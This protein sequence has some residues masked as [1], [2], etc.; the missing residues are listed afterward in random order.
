LL[1]ELAKAVDTEQ[2]EEANRLSATTA[3]LIDTINAITHALYS[4]EGSE[5]QSKPSSFLPFPART[6]QEEKE[7]F[8]NEITPKKET[9]E[10]LFEEIAKGTI[11]AAVIAHLYPLLSDWKRILNER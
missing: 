9:I 10:I 7:E 4:K 6:K 2:E 3:N 1:E 8:E 11:P 5:Y